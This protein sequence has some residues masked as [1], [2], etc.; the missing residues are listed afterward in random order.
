MLAL[1]P[2]RQDCQVAYSRLLAVVFPLIEIGFR[3]QSEAGAKAH[4][5]RFEAS[6]IP[7]NESMTSSFD[8]YSP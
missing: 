8:A 4:P 1:T 5:L 2:G 7:R 3:F 6:G